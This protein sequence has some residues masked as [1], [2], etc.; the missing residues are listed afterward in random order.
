MNDETSV[1]T[2]PHRCPECG[3]PIRMEVIHGE[4]TSVAYECADCRK[5]FTLLDLQIG[6]MHRRLEGW[7]P[8]GS[9][10]HGPTY[11]PE[12]SRDFTRWRCDFPDGVVAR[13]SF[14]SIDLEN[15]QDALWETI[16]GHSLLQGKS[17]DFRVEK[18]GVVLG[19]PPEWDMVRNG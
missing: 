13:V 18:G 3:G 14:R 6:L 2:T 8:E 10:I 11:R 7:V 19:N 12:E 4:D 15:A 1:R 16:Q 5:S 17:G 9:K